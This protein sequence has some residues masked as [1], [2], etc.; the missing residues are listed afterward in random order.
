MAQLDASILT[1]NRAQGSPLDTLAQVQQVFAQ[2]DDAR[3][4][5]EQAQQVRDANIAKAKAAADAQRDDAMVQQAFD[6]AK[7]PTTGAFD[8]DA[9]LNLLAGK[10]NPSTFESVQKF[11]DTHK[12]SVLDNVKTGLETSDLKIKM[13]NAL[14][15]RMKASPQAWA[16]GLPA[17]KAVDETF[18]KGIPQDYDADWISKAE[19]AT[20]TTAQKNE[21][22]RQKL[23]AQ[24]Q[25]PKDL[26]ANLDA[27]KA[28]AGDAPPEAIDGILA[29]AKSAGFMPEALDLFRSMTPEQRTAQ[30]APT[31]QES[32]ARMTAES[33]QK[34]AE[35]QR[36][37]EDRMRTQG[38]TGSS[39]GAAPKSSL[40]EEA[41]NQSADRFY[42]TGVLPPLGAGAAAAAD[43]RAIMQRSAERHPGAILAKNSAEYSANKASY[44]KVTGQLDAVS[45]FEQT[46]LKN[47]E[48]FKELAEKVP[49]TGIPWLNAPIRTVSAG[50][51][52][53]ANMA[54]FN[55][56]RQVALTEISRV[57]SNPGL[58]G[59]LS[60]SAREEVLRLIPESATFAQIKKVAD[61]LTRDMANRKQSLEEQKNII[62]M[63]LGG[64]GAAPAGP[65]VGEVRSANGE[66]RRW[67]GTEWVIVKGGG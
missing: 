21:E 20:K 25:A 2:G 60:D 40:S 34:N 41:L 17:L 67:N 42:S 46:G 19:E 51:V 50:L 7:D 1:Q 63:R 23:Q 48:M 43:K 24:Q 58:T 18:A 30:A 38:P 12:K 33:G 59:V 27:L 45:S 54:A 36:M 22:K 49:D 65:K 5:R 55:A 35:T 44:G 10:V 66:T 31:F 29:T 57:V 52:G 14:L 39:G 47:L 28:F 53:D 8:P 4:R 61:T 6:A 13:G 15:E 9:A 26:M 37:Q 32:T 11:V 56:A 16:A 62:E 64:T 3:A